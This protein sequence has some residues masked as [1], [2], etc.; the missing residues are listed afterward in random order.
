MIVPGECAR[1]LFPKDS[2]C[3]QRD[4]MQRLKWKSLEKSREILWTGTHYLLN[5][6]GI[7]G[8]YFPENPAGGTQLFA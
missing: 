4:E 7:R 3:G 1:P 2:L 8:Q 6:N 5:I